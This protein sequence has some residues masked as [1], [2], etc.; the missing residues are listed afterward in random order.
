M[1]LYNSFVLLFHTINFIHAPAFE[2]LN[3]EL[4]HGGSRGQEQ[5]L[6]SEGYE[7]TNRSCGSISPAVLSSV[8][9]LLSVSLQSRARSTRPKQGQAF[10]FWAF[11]ALFHVDSP[12]GPCLG[13]HAQLRLPTFTLVCREQV[14]QHMDCLSILSIISKKLICRQRKCISRAVNLASFMALS[15][16]EKTF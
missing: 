8:S 6:Q 7:P 16:L 9:L 12:L 10:Q 5:W 2:S 11:C 13:K 15:S 14:L 1:P 3:F 4:P